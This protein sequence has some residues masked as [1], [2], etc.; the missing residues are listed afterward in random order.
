MPAYLVVENRIRD[1]SILDLYI[2]LIDPIIKKYGGRF[3]VR[4][5]KV[6]PLMGGWKPEQMIIL[7][8]PSAEKGRQFGSS[9]EYRELIHLQEQG[10]EMKAVLLEGAAE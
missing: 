4:A 3:L 8:F 10:A 1:A 6:S 2:R 5:G 9:P 7:E